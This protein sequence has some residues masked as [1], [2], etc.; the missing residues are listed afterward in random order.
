MKIDIC[1]F[2]TLEKLLYMC[3]SFNICIP[4]TH[5]AL[6]SIGKGIVLEG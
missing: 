1:I 4:G 5:M 6:V 2:L 3:E